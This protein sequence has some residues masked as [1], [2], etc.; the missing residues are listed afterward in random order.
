M[1]SQASPPIAPPSPA[2]HI[3]PI[4]PPRS[5][6][7]NTPLAHT[8]PT[9]GST[10][11]PIPLP[12]SHLPAP[13]LPP[14]TS[15]VSPNLVGTQIPVTFTPPSPTPPVFTYT[16]TRTSP[17]ATPAGTITPR[18][19][20]QHSS[21]AKSVMTAPAMSRSSSAGGAVQTNGYLLP[22]GAVSK[23]KAV[24][25]GGVGVALSDTPDTT[26]PNSPKLS[27]TPSSPRM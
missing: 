18:K 11:S 4:H 20:A 7:H 21:I 10:I 1:A 12:P 22:P 23:D 27:A 26:A 3:N 5:A 19:Q 8:L 24:G 9:K 13:F 14:N 16:H 2:P 25:S 15:Y 6:G 17:P